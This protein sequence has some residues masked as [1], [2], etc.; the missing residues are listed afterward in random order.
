MSVHTNTKKR[1]IKKKQTFK[2]RKKAALI[3]KY[4]GVRELA[5]ELGMTLK[6]LVPVGIATFPEF[7]PGSSKKEMVHPYCPNILSTPPG[8]CTRE[9]RLGV[10]VKHYVLTKYLV[11]GSRCGSGSVIWMPCPSPTR[12]RVCGATCHTT[13]NNNTK[14]THREQQP[15]QPRLGCVQEASKL[16]QACGVQYNKIEFE[17]L[18]GSDLVT[19]ESELVPRVPVCVL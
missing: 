10:C 11:C 1:A 4:I 19:D 17:L 2:F 14:Q 7:W 12:S 3:P 8:W 9:C 15:Q 18:E 16:A 6:E 5:K 13:Y